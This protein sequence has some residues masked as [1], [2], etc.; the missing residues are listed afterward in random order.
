MPLRHQ[1]RFNFLPFHDIVSRSEYQNVSTSRNPELIAERDCLLC[2]HHSSQRSTLE[3]IFPREGKVELE[4]IQRR[5][6]NLTA[7]DVEAWKTFEL[8]FASVVHNSNKTKDSPH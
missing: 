1:G 4:R 7:D 5:G 8:R 2:T 6:Q 3:S